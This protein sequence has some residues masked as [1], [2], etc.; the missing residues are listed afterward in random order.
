VTTLATRSRG[1]TRKPVRRP[2]G[3]KTHPAP[4]HADI[5]AR[6]YELFVQRGGDHGS[7]WDDWLCAEREL[8]HPQR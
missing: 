8:T 2:A 6:A 4:S 5:A 7:D 3:K 1:N